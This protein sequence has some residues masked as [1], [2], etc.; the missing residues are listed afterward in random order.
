MKESDEIV[1]RLKRRAARA[2]AHCYAPYSRFAVGAAVLSATGQVYGGCN[3]ENASLGLTQC[4]ERV[5]LTAAIADGTP[6]GSVTT[7]VIYTPGTRAHPPCGAC[8]QVMHEL[9][10]PDSLVASCC[11]SDEVRVW[12]RSEHLP[13]PFSPEALSHMRN[14]DP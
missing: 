14:G 6:P 12:R 8:R 11:D 10:A 7:L 4:A 5:A 9:M 1:G 3:V 2:A 13:D